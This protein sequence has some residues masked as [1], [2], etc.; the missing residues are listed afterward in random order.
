MNIKSTLDVGA[1]T[2]SIVGC[3]AYRHRVHLAVLEVREA[4]QA[5]EKAHIFGVEGP[6]DSRRVGGGVEKYARLFGV[7][8]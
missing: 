7:F 6:W 2:Y 1:D 3:S 4:V 5:V 8:W